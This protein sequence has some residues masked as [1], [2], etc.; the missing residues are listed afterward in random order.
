SLNGATG[1]GTAMRRVRLKDG[2]RDSQGERLE[3]NSNTTKGVIF[4]GRRF[5]VESNF[6]VDARVM[7]RLSEEQ[8][9][10]EDASFTTCSGL[11]GERTPWQFKAD[12]ADLEVEG[13]LHARNVRFC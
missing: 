3:F 10:L 11:E 2:V 7:E 1:N 6:T 4:Y 5:V 13:F 8:Y 12:K 9:R